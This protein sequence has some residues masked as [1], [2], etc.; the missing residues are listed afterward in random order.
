MTLEELQESLLI[1]QDTIKLLEDDKRSYEVR[2]SELEAKLKQSELELSK[3]V[4]HNNELF[5]RVA[6]IPTPSIVEDNKEEVIEE[7]EKTW[8]EMVMENYRLPNNLPFNF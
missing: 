2:Q 7:N 1:A 5:R 4:Q 8:K 6:T 3:L